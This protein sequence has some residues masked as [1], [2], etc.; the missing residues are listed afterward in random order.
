MNKKNRY[1]KAAG[2]SVLG[3]L[4]IA[5]FIL[6]T[7]CVKEYASQP[8]VNVQPQTFFWLFPKDTISSGISKQELY[9]WGE[10][11][12][13]YITGYLLA[14]VPN[15]T[16]IPSPDTLTYSYVTCTDSLISF[17]LRQSVQTFLVAVRAIDNSYGG[18][19]TV[20]VHV[21]L[22][23]ATTSTPFLDKNQNGIFDSTDVSLPGLTDA[24]DPNGAKQQF[25]TSNTAPTIA[26]VYDTNNDTLYA[27]PP[28]QTFTVAGFSWAGSDYDGNETIASY[29]ISL[30]DSL[31]TNPLSVSSSV[32]TVTLAVSRSVSD[33]ATS[34]TVSADVYSGT[35]PG[36][37][38]EG[39]LSGMKLDAENHLYVKAVDVANAKSKFISFP[40]AGRA[41][42]V[43]KPRGNV[44][45]VV[46]DDAT[47]W[48]SVQSYY[49]D[50]VLSKITGVTVDTLNVADGNMIPSGQHINPALTKTLKL[51]DCVVWFT[52]PSP[53]LDLARQVLYDY[54]SSA[55]GGHLIYSAHYADPNAIPDAGAAYRDI[56]PI[57][58]LASSPL[59]VTKFSGMLLADS[60]VTG[61]EYPM[62]Q[63]K[64]KSAGAGICIFPIYPNAAAR[65]IY[66][67]P[68]T[69][70][71]AKTTVG[72]I[73]ETKRVIFFNFPLSRLS[74][75]ST[76]GSGTLDFFKKAFSEFGLQ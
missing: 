23:T 39:T 36:L 54:W 7:G 61:D 72:V 24:M 48:S 53:N 37:H 26:Y 45:L 60:T 41:W 28:L 63:F 15:L 3:L 55:D 68:A 76:T 69:S 33:A 56:A 34:S 21:K 27:Q 67:L 44:L 19:L 18:S 74:A 31:F 40:T 58:G 25:P 11:E 35:S 17:P 9:W 59:S 2:I 12:D 29:Q 73:D 42:H 70:S 51:Y 38:K 64:S 71:Y 46:D 57:D 43:K 13:G 5:A 75:T 1:R 66:S 30:N 32:T 22:N 14:I 52:D 49:V 20:G 47:D 4:V 6:Q 62:M 8:H 65:V 10:D 50:S 16:A